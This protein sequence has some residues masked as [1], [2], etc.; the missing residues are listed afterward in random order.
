MI[1]FKHFQPFNKEAIIKENNSY[2]KLL[3]YYHVAFSMSREEL[4]HLNIPIE[5][6]E[7]DIILKQ[8]Y[9]R[10]LVALQEIHEKYPRCLTT[11]YKYVNY[12]DFFDSYEFRF[13]IGVYD[14]EKREIS[15][16]VENIL[17]S[18][19]DHLELADCLGAAD[20]CNLREGIVKILGGVRWKRLMLVMGK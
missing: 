8:L 7:E 16:E 1:E 17:S 12:N 13:F 10:Y 9:C 14:A 5:V 20:I 11:F 15:T 2:L 19:S 6:A 18:I 3:D 4:L